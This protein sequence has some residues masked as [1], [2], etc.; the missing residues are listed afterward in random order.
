[1]VRQRQTPKT[2]NKQW[3]NVLKY[4]HANTCFQK[5]M[6]INKKHGLK[7]LVTYASLVNYL[8][9]LLLLAHDFKFR[10]S[11]NELHFLLPNV[12]CLPVQFT[13]FDQVL[14]AWHSE[15]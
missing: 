11:I 7:Y 14:L 12:L 10:D 15:V 2:N 9:K 8:R 3:D 6:P 4:E 1:M 5:P 13:T